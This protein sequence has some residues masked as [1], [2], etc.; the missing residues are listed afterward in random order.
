MEDGGLQAARAMLLAAAVCAV[1]G[2]AGAGN[3][4][5]ANTAAAASGEQGF[6][7][8][9]KLTDAKRA[10]DG[11][12]LIGQ[13]SP[14]AAV[15]L[16]NATGGAQFATADAQGVW[17][18]TI[19]ASGEARLYSLAMSDQGRISPATGYLFVMPDGAVARLV[20]GGGSLML[21]PDA[22]A[23]VSLALDYD[24]RAAATLSGADAPAAAQSLR[25]DGVERGQSVADPQGRFV[26]PLNQPLTPGAHDFDLG[27]GKGELR[28]SAA[29]SAPAQL[30]G[31]FA[32]QPISGGWRAD[33][34]TPGGGEQTTLVFEALAPA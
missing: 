26:L 18:I 2:C 12:T 14:G 34:I 25:V 33:W 27:S 8:A 31:P 5:A 4:A 1:A 29:I 7:P 30:R 19:G 16:E 22:P 6:R 32:A 17:R 10:A 3:E 24:N 13:A 21:T 23:R 28:F 15:R 11:V 20:A 9:P